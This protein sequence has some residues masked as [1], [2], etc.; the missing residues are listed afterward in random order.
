[1]EACPQKIDPY[2]YPKIEKW[3][4]SSNWNAP[5]LCF[6]PQKI[7]NIFLKLFDFDARLT[8]LN[9]A[10]YFFIFSIFAVV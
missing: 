7:L 2:H 9:M 3:P 6:W 1:M 5:F 10:E 8:I 4:G